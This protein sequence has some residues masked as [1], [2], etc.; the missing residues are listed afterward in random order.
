M[1]S[2]SKG[3]Y[4]QL[5][6][7]S[8]PNTKLKEANT[9]IKSNMIESLLQS[10]SLNQ[11]NNKLGANVNINLNLNKNSNNINNNS[12]AINLANLNHTSNLNNP[13][14][15]NS[16]SF[17]QG[18]LIAKKYKTSKNSRKCLKFI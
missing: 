16:S 3:K 9:K 13:I 15:P 12:N 10:S 11:K 14:N 5:N 1:T 7:N 8:N 4:Y 2:K 17:R 18:G 6:L